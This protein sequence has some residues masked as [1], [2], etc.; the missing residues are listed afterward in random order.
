LQTY[1]FYNKCRQQVKYCK[2]DMWWKRWEIM[3]RDY[4]GN[5]NAS[6]VDAVS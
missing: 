2:P 4:C 3:K 5:K 6:Y 1:I